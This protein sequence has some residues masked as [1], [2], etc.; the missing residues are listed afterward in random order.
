MT[1]AGCFTGKARKHESR[2]ALDVRAAGRP[3]DTCPGFVQTGTEM[4]VKESSRRTETRFLGRAASDVEHGDTCQYKIRTCRQH[5]QARVPGK[6][7][8]SQSC[9][10]GAETRVQGWFRCAGSTSWSRCRSFARGGLSD[11]CQGLVQTCQT[12]QV[13]PRDT[14]QGLIPD[15]RAAEVVPGGH[16]EEW[17]SL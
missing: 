8:Q 3:G 1:R 16:E 6:L 5:K 9:Q 4:R 14:C 17:R 12:A 15:V 13:V 11:T 2:D 10:A 7:S